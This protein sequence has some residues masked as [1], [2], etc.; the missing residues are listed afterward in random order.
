RKAIGLSAGNYS[1]TFTDFN[2]CSSTATVTVS[3]NSTF[4]VSASAN[5]SICPGANASLSV[6][7]GTSYLWSTSATTAGINVTPLVKTTYSVSVI[8]GTCHKDTSVMVNVR[9][10]PTI[11]IAGNTTIFF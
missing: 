11:I 6:S 7:G 10:L 1:V 9:P 4:S 2:G 8:Y 5:I 3:T